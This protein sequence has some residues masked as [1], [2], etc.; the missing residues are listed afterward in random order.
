MCI[1]IC[2]YIKI[3]GGYLS[4]KLEGIYTFFLLHRT[5][6]NLSAKSSILELK[7]SLRN[8]LHLFG[9]NYNKLDYYKY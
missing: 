7:M 5:F 6:L 3:R 1:S 4:I 2:M 9:A 8:T